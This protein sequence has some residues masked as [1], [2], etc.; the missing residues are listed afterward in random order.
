M[1][2]SLD[3]ASFRALTS[4]MHGSAY[5]K[6]LA[7][8]EVLVRRYEQLGPE[9]GSRYLQALYE[10]Y[11]QLIAHRGAMVAYNI[12][13]TITESFTLGGYIRPFLE[14]YLAKGDDATT[15]V[16]TQRNANRPNFEYWIYRVILSEDGVAIPEA[17]ARITDDI[18][19]LIMEG[20]LVYAPSALADRL[21]YL[22]NSLQYDLPSACRNNLPAPRG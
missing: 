14:H 10:Y 20:A 11:E 2:S 8:P 6:L 9:R 7:Y 16:P 4:R 13:T 5:D 22:F 3:S 17:V 18:M 21:G 12:M 15:T 19:E 1:F